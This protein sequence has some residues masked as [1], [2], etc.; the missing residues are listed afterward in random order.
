MEAGQTVGNPEPTVFAD[1]AKEAIEANMPLAEAKDVILEAAIPKKLP[2]IMVDSEMIKRV[3]INLVENALKYSP[4]ESKVTV[5]AKR[6]GEWLRAWV[7]DEGRGI[8]KGEQ[9]KIFEKFSRVQK[10]ST[11]NTKG[12]GLGLAYCKLAVEGHGG[13]I[14]VDSEAGKGAKFLFTVP[15]I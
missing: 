11:G 13:K 14:W 1:L 4:G 10:G 5:G 3:I 12:L 6:D 2:K 7:L 15:I 8:P 9:T